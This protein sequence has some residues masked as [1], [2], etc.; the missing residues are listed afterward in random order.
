MDTK[1]IFKVIVTVLVLTALAIGGFSIWEYGQI[2]KLISKN[3]ETEAHLQE[4]E[5]ELAG[6][7]ADIKMVFQAKHISCEGDLK[8]CLSQEVMRYKE[9]SKIAHINFS[10]P[11]I[12]WREQSEVDY[13]SKDFSLAELSVV[14]VSIGEIPLSKYDKKEN[15]E[16]AKE[17]EKAFAI[18]FDVQPNVLKPGSIYFHMKRI[19]SNEKGTISPNTSQFYFPDV[20]GMG[21]RDARVYA[22]QRFVFIVPTDEK[23]FTFSTGGTPNII[24]TVMRKDDGGITV[25]KN[26]LS[27]KSSQRTTPP[28]TQTIDIT[29]PGSESISL[30]E[31]YPTTIN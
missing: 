22:P 20:G 5:G 18:A 24:F 14:G 25:E 8:V 3:N 15:G 6:I 31:I 28:K 26:S 7:I 13:Y 2:E 30:P 12:V 17:G 16:F 29:L 4:K 23:E 19:L 1:P 11:T 9:L 10:K 21:A 27:S